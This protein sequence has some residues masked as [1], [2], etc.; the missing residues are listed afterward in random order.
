VRLGQTATVLLELPRS[1]GVTR[2]PLSA[3]AEL[4]GKTVVWL[5]DPATLTVRPQ[6]VSVAGADGNS[7]VVSAGLAP[8]Q[9]V[10]TA[11]VHLLTPGQKVKRYVEPVVAATG[12]A[13]ASGAAR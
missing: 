6:T 13:P 10:V 9:T 3:V 11:G 12:A 5:L 4:Q 1:A 7:V 2:L 8:G